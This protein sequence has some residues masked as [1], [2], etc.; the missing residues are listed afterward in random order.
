MKDLLTNEIK[1]IGSQDGILAKAQKTQAAGI[2]KPYSWSGPLNGW[3]TPS[4]GGVF[5]S[6][7]STTRVLIVSVVV[8]VRFKGI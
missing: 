7:L 4:Y 1:I 5:S 6:S 2:A 8:E 3:K